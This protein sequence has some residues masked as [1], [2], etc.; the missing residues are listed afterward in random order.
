M[1]WQHDLK[2]YRIKTVEENK[3]INRG[4]AVRTLTLFKSEF[5]F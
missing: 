2:D 4:A 3:K 5:F 1:F